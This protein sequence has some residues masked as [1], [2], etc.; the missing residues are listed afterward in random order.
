M[1]I[2]QISEGQPTATATANR[3]GMRDILSRVLYLG[4]CLV[5]MT[6][7]IDS[8]S[9]LIGGDFGTI[10]QTGTPR[11]SWRDRSQKVRHDP[12]LTLLMVIL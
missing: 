4:V 10:A 6:R 11:M 1:C 9:Q 2:T 12:P 8:V 3:S 7:P 5:L